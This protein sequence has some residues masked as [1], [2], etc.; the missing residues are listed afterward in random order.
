MVSKA[1]IVQM[2]YNLFDSY[3]SDNSGYLDVKE[4]KIVMK[5]VFGE[6]NKKQ[7]I[8]DIYLNKAMMIYDSNGDNKISRK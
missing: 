7:P 4:F 1:D 3:D 2:A 8:D 6:V 5:Q